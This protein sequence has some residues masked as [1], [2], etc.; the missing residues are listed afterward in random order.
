MN[1]YRDRIKQLRGEGLSCWVISKKLR[2]PRADLTAFVQ[3]MEQ[4]EPASMLEL[5]QAR[6]Q[7]AQA[8][9]RVE[10]LREA[11][12]SLIERLERMEREAKATAQALQDMEREHRQA[13]YRLRQGSPSSQPEPEPVEEQAAP[14]AAEDGWSQWMA[15]RE[16]AKLNKVIPHTYYA[17]LR[18]GHRPDGRRV[19]RRKVTASD[20]VHGHTSMLTRFEL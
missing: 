6:A 12:L 4:P 17:W 15:V 18:K 16:A 1:Q 9:A 3:A 8:T 11:N 19:Q 5:M 13:L 10:R 7:V 2:V 14:V 20:Q